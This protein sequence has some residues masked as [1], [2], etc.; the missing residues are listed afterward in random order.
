[1]TDAPKVSVCVLVYNHA[2]VIESTLK[3]ILDQSLQDCEVIVS[4]DCS[5]DGTW[6]VLQAIQAREPRV[7]AI[8]T[9]QNLGMAGN[10]N[11]AVQ[12][13]TGKY[14]AL[15]HHDD[16][17]RRDLLEKWLGPLECHNDVNFVF[18]GYSQENGVD[19]LEPIK[20]KRIDGKRFLEEFLF[21]RWGCPVRGTAMVRRSA[22]ERV[23]GMR[24]EFGLLADIDLWMRLSMEDAV[25]YVREPLIFIRHARP[26]Y[27]PDIY[28]YT[29]WS[30]QRLVFLYMIHGD[31]RRVYFSGSHGG[32]PIAWLWFR[33]R[34]SI[35]TTKWITYAVVRRKWAMVASCSESATPYD[36]FI[37]RIYRSLV[38]KTV[39]LARLPRDRVAK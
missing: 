17:Y 30:W 10:A 3:T 26:D 27:Y 4:D 20:Q 11:F 9:P 19:V 23:G 15:L 28:K 2:N 22:W 5:N 37:L 29:H 34:L 39:H 6:D 1:M 14:I 36:L 21:P 8:R 25:G 33:F 32:R 13:T 16:L 12:A 18:N 38:L 35:E 24:P 7:R 31:N